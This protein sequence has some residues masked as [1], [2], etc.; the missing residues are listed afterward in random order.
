MQ[1]R[2][3]Y[4]NQSSKALVRCGH[5]PARVPGP[6]GVHPPGSDDFEATAVEWL[7][8]VSP[9]EY[10]QYAVLRR[11]PAA[12]A[13]AARH[14]AVACVEGAR[15]GYRT[16]RT[17][18]GEHIPPHAV[19]AVLNAY[20]SEGKRLVATARAVELVERALRGEVSGV[21]LIS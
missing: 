17:E 3:R 6:A 8:Q 9:A 15:Q 11:C 4:S 16:V 10:R 12:L 2:A 19:D 20:H 14:H 5:D 7:L 1:V 21:R 13:A 18:L